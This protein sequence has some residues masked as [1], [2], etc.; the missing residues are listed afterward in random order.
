[1]KLQRLLL[2]SSHLAALPP[3]VERKG[4]NPVVMK[5]SEAFVNNCY[6]CALCLARFLWEQPSQDWTKVACVFTDNKYQR[7]GRKEGNCLDLEQNNIHQ[8]G[9]SGF[10]TTNIT[11]KPT[12]N[13]QQKRSHSVS[14]LIWW[15]VIDF[16]LKL[17]SQCTENKMKVTLFAGQSPP[18]LV[19]KC[20]TI[21]WSSSPFS[22]QRKLLSTAFFSSWH[23][24]QK[25][26][27]TEIQ[28]AQV[29]NQLSQPLPWSS[30]W[31]AH[32]FWASCQAGY[33]Q[34]HAVKR[35]EPVLPKL[36]PETAGPLQSIMPKLKS[37][38]W[39]Q[40]HPN[41]ARWI[42]GPQGSVPAVHCVRW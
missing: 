30:L 29:Q 1:M 8:A 22:M 35:A 16:S 20:S 3:A 40:C 39:M 38:A 31:T 9:L 15:S 18:L 10:T 25:S 2:S 28:R 13:Q 42:S 23:G 41:A 34:K 26:L 21:N 5:I 6:A 4:A 19:L 14:G 11:K 17:Y 24:I 7:D 27:Y 32:S 12:P 33:N 37:H 36:K